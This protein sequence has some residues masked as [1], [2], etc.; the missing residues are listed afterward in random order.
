LTG[1]VLPTE[2]HCP[3]LMPATTAAGHNVAPPERVC[4]SPFGSAK[5]ASSAR[6]LGASTCGR[7]LSVK[8]PE[9]LR[10]SVTASLSA[11][12]LAPSSEGG[13]ESLSSSSEAEVSSPVRGV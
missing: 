8:A 1:T 5:V 13:C 3:D 9:P 6:R 12:S 2:T 7:F 11:I 10:S 4:T